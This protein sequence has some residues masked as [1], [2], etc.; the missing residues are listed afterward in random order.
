MSDV[1][2]QP[3]FFSFYDHTAIQKRLEEMAAAGWLL[4]KPGNLFWKYRRVPPQRIHIAITYFPDASDFDPGPSRDQQTMEDYCARD[5]WTL[6]CRWGQ[7]QIFF[8]TLEDPVPIDT[9]PVIQVRTIHRAMK[10]NMLPGH[11]LLL[12]VILLQLGML[13]LD[14]R[15]DPIDFLATPSSL[16]LLPMWVLL[17]LAVL[18]EL[19]FYFWWRHRAIAEAEDG[20]F[21]PIRTHRRM[22]F[23]LV[24]AAMFLLLLSLVS[25]GSAF[26]IGTMLLWMAGYGLI[27]LLANRV[28]GFLKD[29]GAPRW[30]NLTATVVLVFAATIALLIGITAAVISGHIPWQEQQAA[31]HYEYRGETFPIYAD[32][33]PLRLEDLGEIG[34]TRYQ[35][36]AKR[37][38][39][40]L[41][42]RTRYEQ[43][44]LLIDHDPQAP[45]LHYTVIRVK[46][47][48]LY[49]L[50]KQAVL[51][52]ERDKVEWQ[53][54]VLMDPV[55]WG[56]EEAYQEYSMNLW[57]R[58]DFPMKDYCLFWEDKMAIVHLY[59]WE[60]SDPD[61]LTPE[62]MAVIGEKLRSP[63][64]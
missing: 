37:E 47:P 50:C 8:S 2:Y 49:D 61:G 52:E 57:G 43:S 28:K 6:L 18:Y 19:G 48:F 64:V 58:G 38:E 53:H 3:E 63:G 17:A 15:R 25:M 59:P 14:F 62:R 10:R 27:L 51:K 42:S 7:M 22:S 11:L 20:V 9:D 44:Q 46:A 12:L 5:G 29:R 56:V 30:L 60:A 40:F 32:P 24:G 54:F 16:Y 26:R 13:L 31:G 33:I 21:L 45:S 1:R 39:T 41:L 23:L 34:E 35:T 36:E 55:P 4:Q